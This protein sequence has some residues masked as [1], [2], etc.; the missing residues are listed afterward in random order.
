ML[1]AKSF[2]NISGE[3]EEDLEKMFQDLQYNNEINKIG[4]NSKNF[5]SSYSG[6]SR[7]YYHRTTPEDIL[8]KK[9]YYHTQ[10]SCSGD[11]IYC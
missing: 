6:S 3:D 10:L 5:D 11:Q 1:K 8:Y 4:Y 9:N 2:E 7:H